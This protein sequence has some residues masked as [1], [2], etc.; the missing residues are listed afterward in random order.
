MRYHISKHRTFSEEQASKT[1][2]LEFFIAC[3]LLIFDY[4]HFNN[5]IH[6]DIKPE[7][8]ILDDKGYLRLTDFGIS[9]FFK[10][11]NSQETSGTPGYMAPEIMCGLNH[12]F[13][14]DYFAIGVFGYEMM[15]GKVWGLILEALLWQKQERGQGEYPSQAGEDQG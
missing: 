15:F 7:N 1:I 5:V 6:R 13:V 8:M 14:S 3:L 4:L 11:E 2:N 12:S 10:R 9:K